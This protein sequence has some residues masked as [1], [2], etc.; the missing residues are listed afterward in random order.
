MFIH[1]DPASSYHEFRYLRLLLLAGAY[2]IT[3]S[4]SCY[5]S[6]LHPQ[7]CSNITAID[8]VHTKHWKGKPGKKI[9]RHLPAPSFSSS[10][11]FV[12]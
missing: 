4:R 6:G 1:S 9:S 8:V 3:I 11:C 5:S 10:S 7:I 12:K 2:N